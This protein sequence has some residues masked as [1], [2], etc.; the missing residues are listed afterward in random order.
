MRFILLV[1]FTLLPF[2]VERKFFGVWVTSSDVLIL[3]AILFWIF[4]AASKKISLKDL[5]FPLLLPIILLMATYILSILSAINPL[6]SFTKVIK[7]CML[8]V[9]FYLAVNNITEKKYLL[10]LIYAITASVTLL[11]MFFISETLQLSSD[12][13]MDMLVRTRMWERHFFSPLHLN[14]LGVILAVGIPF[15]LFG[16]FDKKTIQ[17]KLPFIF[18]LLIQAGA[19]ALTYSRGNWIALAVVLLI[20]FV[21]RYRIKGV[22]ISALLALL[23]VFVMT[24]LFSSANLGN[25]IFSVVDSGDESYISRLDHL[26]YG[27]KLFKLKPLTG[28]GVGNFQA[29]AKKYFGADLVEIVHNQFLQ[30]AVDAGIFC[31]LFMLFLIV[32]YLMDSI[33]VFRGIPDDH[34]LRDLTLISILSFGAMILSAQFG[35]IFTRYS[36]EYFVLVLALPYAVKSISSSDK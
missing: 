22:I 26:K 7:L 25:R 11:S 35:D 17:G 19:M 23:T 10:R 30:C 33:S 32:K 31:A 34:T 2:S 9:F 6:L 4:Q 20:L 13:M 12:M 8:F 27:Y 29:A 28:V 5:K 14:L 15:C 16:L 3:A 18:A 36:K 21:V 24:G 1:I